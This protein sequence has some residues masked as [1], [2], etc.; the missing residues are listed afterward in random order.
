MS[1]TEQYNAAIDAFKPIARRIL[2]VCTG[3]H[4]AKLRSTGDMVRDV[5]CKTLDVPY[6]TQS[7]KLIINDVKSNDLQYKVYMTHPDNG[8]IRSSHP[9]P[10]MREAA[11]KVQLKRRLTRERMADCILNI[12]AHFHKA[13]TVEPFQELYLVDDG[14]KIKQRYKAEADAHAE[15]IDEDLRWYGSV[16]GWIKKYSL[17]RSGYVERAGYAPLPIGCLKTVVRDG[18]IVR[19]EKKLI[20]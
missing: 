11:E 5:F 13:I 7:C 10:I 1:I 4:D 14:D 18:K 19:M 15:Y 2:A 17:G 20:Q 6:G 3:N 12:A 8:T 16:P 9:D